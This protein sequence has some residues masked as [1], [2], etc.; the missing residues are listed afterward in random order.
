VLLIVRSLPPGLRV[1][2]WRV[3]VAVLVAVGVYGLGS[4]LAWWLL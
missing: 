4:L 1:N 2:G 3:G